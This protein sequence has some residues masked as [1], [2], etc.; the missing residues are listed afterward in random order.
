MELSRE[1]KYLGA[2]R[3]QTFLEFSNEKSKKEYN[4]GSNDMQRRN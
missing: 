1:T 3:R 2:V 4:K